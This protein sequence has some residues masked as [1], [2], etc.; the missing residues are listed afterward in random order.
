MAK[1]TV[2]QIN[3][4]LKAQMAELEAQIK[5]NEEEAKQEVVSSIDQLLEDSG[6]ELKELYPD[7]FP[8]T[9]TGR[10]VPPVKLKIGEWIG[11]IKTRP[12]DDIKAALLKIGENPEKF[13]T[14]QS[15]VDKFE[16]KEN[17]VA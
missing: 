4:E 7:L 6:F 8:K 11:E 3:A 17:N 14:K 9:A 13:T 2:A 10:T 16:L 15:L 1:K 5:A 12:T